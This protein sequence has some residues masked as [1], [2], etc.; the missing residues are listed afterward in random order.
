MK[1]TLLF[2]LLGAGAYYLCK[3]SDAVKAHIPKDSFLW[4][5]YGP[6]V[7]IGGFCVLGMLVASMTRKKKKA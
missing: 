1:L 5:T 4:S 6:A 3:Y 7:V 2:G